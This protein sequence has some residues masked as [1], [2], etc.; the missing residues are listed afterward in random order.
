M[1]IQ[2][3][4]EIDIERGVIYFHP[5][6]GPL[7]GGSLLRICSLPVPIRTDGLIDINAST[8][9]RRRIVAPKSI[10]RVFASQE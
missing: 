8:S 5:S 10:I 2:G 7:K 3:Q 4:L 1:T 6:E 9:F